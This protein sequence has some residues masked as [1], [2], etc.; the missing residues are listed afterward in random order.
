MNDCC[1]KSAC[2][3]SMAA[4]YTTALMIPVLFEMLSMILSDF[5]LIGI[6]GFLRI[7]IR[8]IGGLRICTYQISTYF[9][10]CVIAFL[11]V[12]RCMGG[13]AGIGTASSAGGQIPDQFPKI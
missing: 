1:L 7:F 3:L 10:S 4:I 8:T 11:A 5:L 13:S 12:E 9:I 2:F 6:I